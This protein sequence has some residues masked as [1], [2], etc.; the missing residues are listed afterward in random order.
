MDLYNKRIALVTYT[1]YNYL[2]KAKM[3]I[4]SIRTNGKYYGD[5]VVITDGLF[6]ID[7][8]Y[9]FRMNLIIKEYPDIDVTKLLEKIREHPF[10]NSDGRELYKIKQWNKLYVFDTYFKQWDYIMFLDAGIMI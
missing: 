3:T 5:L 6:Q 2:P 4:G 9:I 7:K 1:D 10:T 8:E